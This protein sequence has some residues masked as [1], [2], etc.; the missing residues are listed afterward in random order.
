M[1]RPVKNMHALSCATPEHIGVLVRLSPR[2]QSASVHG[3]P[4]PAASAPKHSEPPA[5]AA[6][7]ARDLELARRTARPNEPVLL[8][9][10]EF[11]ALGRPEALEQA[12]ELM[13]G[14]SLKPWPILQDLHQLGSVYG[15]RAGT[16]FSNAGLI[17]IFNVGN[18]ETAT[19]VPILL[20]AVTIAYQTWRVWPRRAW[21]CWPLGARSPRRPCGSLIGFR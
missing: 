9:L 16:F 20:G 11:A 12:F 3:A 8:R 19:W 17:Q 5:T 13:A 18:V 21:M 4:C 10:D 6:G 1:C 15:E 7:H 14:Y 2:V